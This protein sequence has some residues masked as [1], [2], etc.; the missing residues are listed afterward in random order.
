MTTAPNTFQRIF[1]TVFADYLHKWL[2]IYV[3]D[4]LQWAKTVEGALAQYTL[5]FPRLVKVGSQLKP[6]DRIF[7]ARNIELLGHRVTQEGRTPISKG[8]EAIV[9]M[10]TPNNT[11]AVKRF[12]GLCG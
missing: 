4:I 5:L 9:S 2:V 10:P 6:T 1:N 7:F 11:S 3:D 8:V 12:L